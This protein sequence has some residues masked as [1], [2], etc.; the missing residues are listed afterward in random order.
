MPIF[1]G[2]KPLLCGFL[3]T[4]PL[5]KCFFGTKMVC[6]ANK[7]V[8]PK[9]PTPNPSKTFSIL[10]KSTVD[11]VNAMSPLSYINHTNTSAGWTVVDKGDDWYEL[12]TAF[13]VSMFHMKVNTTT[14]TIT[15]IVLAKSR[16]PCDFAGG[17]T[18]LYRLETFQVGSSV[19]HA[20]SMNYTFASNPSL[21]YIDLTPA[22]FGTHAMNFQHMFAST[23]KLRFVS[24]INTRNTISN[25]RNDM[26]VNS[27][28][29]RPSRDEQT[30]L[31][32]S[33]GS[34]F[35]F[36]ITRMSDNND[37]KVSPKTAYNY[38][39]IVFDNKKYGGSHHSSLK[40][41]YA[42]SSTVGYEQLEW[43]RGQ[44]HSFSANQ[45]K[46]G[47]PFIK[48]VDRNHSTYWL[49]YHWGNGHFEWWYRTP[50]SFDSFR[51]KANGHSSTNAGDSAAHATG[52][53]FRVEA[54]N[55]TSQ[56]WTHIQTHRVMD[57]GNYGDW[58][59]DENRTILIND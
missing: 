31:Q 4:K 28:V 11:L 1:L 32:N 3:G 6:D 55:T 57:S 29:L 34:K 54:R 9:S 43:A 7:F 16:Y 21:K 44:L 8:F 15:N 47:Y 26:F 53:N 37:W 23:P 51:L 27:R 46:S 24:Y 35:Q 40:E 19:T 39:R 48:M 22:F 18:S 59:T 13:Q 20:T 30:A 5:D 2:N 33:W 17:F 38:W 12:S 45:A 52:R 25:G 14:E 49:S 36:D 50:Q 58:S 41:I 56:A 10:M 42:Y